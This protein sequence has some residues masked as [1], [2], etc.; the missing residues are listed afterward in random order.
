MFNFKYC[1][2]MNGIDFSKIS[3]IKTIRTV[4][5]DNGID[6]GLKE[7]KELVDMEKQ[8]IF[9]DLF[10]EEKISYVLGVLLSKGIKFETNVICNNVSKKYPFEQKGYIRAQIN[11][12][13]DKFEETGDL[14]FA[15]T[16]CEMQNA[17]INNV[18][19]VATATG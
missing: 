17:F 7:A 10:S 5:N 19:H 4:F 9:S 16:A 2:H 3:A 6:L 18:H 13:F 12:L 14:K 15:D 11:W 1:G 8:F